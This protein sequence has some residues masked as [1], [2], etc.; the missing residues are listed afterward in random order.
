MPTTIDTVRTKVRTVS[1][2]IKATWPD[3]SLIIEYD[4]AELVNFETQ[5]KPFLR[6]VLKPGG[7]MQADLAKNPVHRITG[8]LAIEAWYKKNTGNKA[9]DELLSFWYPKIHMTDQ[10]YPIRT[11][12]AQLFDRT[13]GEGWEVLAA[14][15]PVWWDSFPE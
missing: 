10:H 9:A 5:T 11:Y 7:G 8:V 6:V 12:A 4:K 1:E 3:S 2:A 14:A 15:I 13:A